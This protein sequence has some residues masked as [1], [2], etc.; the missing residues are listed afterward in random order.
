MNN[1]QSARHKEQ[2][3]KNSF[4]YL[5]PVLV[6]NLIPIISLPIFTRVL[7]KEDFG[8][9][10]L[11]QVYAFF[12]T[13]C[14]NFGL[15]TT[16]ERNF[17]QYEAE[18]KK[19]S[20]LLYSTLLFVI[21]AILLLT[22]ATFFLQR[23]ISRWIIGSEH[24]GNL[25]FLTFCAASIMSL[26]VYY[27][28]YFKNTENAK[29]F[30]WYTID[31]NLIGFLLSF[32][33]I[34][35]FKVGVLSL[36]YG[37]L[38]SS[39]II[40]SLL[41]YRFLKTHPFIFDWKILKDSLKISYPLTPRIFMGVIGNQFDKYLLGLINSIGGV[42][43]YSIGQKIANIVFV[44][45]TA[46]Q[47]VFSPQVYKKMFN[48]GTQG[49]KA[50][51][52]Y[53]TPF[54]Y[55]STAVALMIVL[56]SEEIVM[57]MLPTPYYGAI[58]IISLFAMYYGFLFFGKQPQLLFAKKTFLTSILTIGY[59]LINVAINIPF[60]KLW[61]G[62][63]AAWGTLISG[64]I[65]VGAS[66][67]ISQKYYR[68][69]WEKKAIISIYLTLAIATLLTVT[70]RHFDA[71]Y[72]IRLSFKL[73]MLLIYALVGVKLGILTRHN[74]AL[75]KSLIPTRMKLEPSQP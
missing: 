39:L 67:V 44:Y 59:I 75:I 15:S 63:G 43:I 2:Q 48:L 28:T 3:I 23:P 20:A 14:A 21:F 65:Y 19:G 68:I 35:Y 47:N 36:P 13:G 74:A 49:G 69:E 5:L 37:Q 70:L 27:L 34:V 66:F 73:I 60:I 26:K 12:I 17:F 45:M 4:V 11:A 52:H 53:L 51:G 38:I 6:G 9:F 29:S 46:I 58:D 64:L 50:I 24:Y 8:A 72:L 71:L 32:I 40:F 25:L 55:I 54:A 22:V 56:F 31:E 18:P 57:L 7:S 1:A 61:G 30:S 10:A 62:V 42:G 16:Y 41:T 33:L